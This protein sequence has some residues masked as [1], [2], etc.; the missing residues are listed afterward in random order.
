MKVLTEAALRCAFKASGVPAVYPLERGWIVTPSARQ[1]LRELR[2]ELA[3]PSRSAGQTSLVD[4]PVEPSVTVYRSVEDGREFAKKPEDMTQLRGRL[5][6]TKTHPRIFLRGRLDSL[7][8]LILEQEARAIE[9]RRPTLAKDLN[10]MLALARGITRAEVLEEPLSVEQMLGLD[11]ETMH[12][13]SHT[14]K[15]YFG[16]GHV[17]PSAEM[18]AAMLGLN[19]LR[20]EVREVE[21]LAITAFA[22]DQGCERLDLVTAL[23]H[24]SSAVYVMMLRE[25]SGYYKTGRR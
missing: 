21:L 25:R 12:Q 22:S 4:G 20:C 17:M 3:E 5:L 8:A 16:I 7:Q 1:Y 18:G 2:V 6:V 19:R 10:E 13:Q 15:R 11:I 9:T 14:P 23:N 24:M